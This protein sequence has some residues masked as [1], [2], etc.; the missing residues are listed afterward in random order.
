MAPPN[1]KPGVAYLLFLVFLLARKLKIG[2][3]ADEAAGWLAGSQR[4]F[5]FRSI[6]FFRG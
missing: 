4:F 3:R 6:V 5:C 2:R 1:T